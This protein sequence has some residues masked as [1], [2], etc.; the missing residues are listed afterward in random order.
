MPVTVAATLMHTI[1]FV[2]ES[3]NPLEKTIDGSKL[4]RLNEPKL[5][6]LGLDDADCEIILARLQLLERMYRRSQTVSQRPSIS[7]ASVLNETT[8]A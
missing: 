1:L 6:A 7:T 2:D 5:K 3:T 4:L 8:P